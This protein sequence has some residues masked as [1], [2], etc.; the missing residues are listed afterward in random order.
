MEQLSIVR[1][2]TIY[3]LYSSRN[4]NYDLHKGNAFIEFLVRSC[5]GPEDTNFGLP[6][7]KIRYRD[8]FRLQNVL[9]HCNTRKCAFLCLSQNIKA[10]ILSIVSLFHLFVVY[11]AQIFFQLFIILLKKYCSW[12]SMGKESLIRTSQAFANF[13]PYIS[14]KT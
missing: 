5:R 10:W 13:S 1:L 9:D 8:N 4:I 6:A 7:D 14:G 12:Y 11:Q 3:F 2:T